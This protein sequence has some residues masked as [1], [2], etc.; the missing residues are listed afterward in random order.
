MVEDVNV[1]AFWAHDGSPIAGLRVRC[2]ETD[3]SGVTDFNGR[4]SFSISGSGFEATSIL[5]RAGTG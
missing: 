2:F 4:V 3:Q 5:L 1:R